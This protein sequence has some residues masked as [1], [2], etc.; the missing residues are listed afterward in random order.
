MFQHIKSVFGWQFL[1]CL[2]YSYKRV[3]THTSPMTKTRVVKSH[4]FFIALS[5]R[6]RV[7]QQFTTVSS[8]KL[9]T[10]NSRIWGSDPQLYH[11]FCPTVSHQHYLSHRGWLTSSPKK[12]ALMHMRK[13]WW[14]FDGLKRGPMSSECWWILWLTTSLTLLPVTQNCQHFIDSWISHQRP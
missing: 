5:L 12:L 7:W 1:G 3:P 10:E 4:R 14:F 2:G 9:L 11:A 6:N 8:P 13:A